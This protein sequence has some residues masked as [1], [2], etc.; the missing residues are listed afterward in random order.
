MTPEQAAEEIMH[1]DLEHVIDGKNPYV[2]ILE[3][4]LKVVEF[5]CQHPGC[6]IANNALRTQLSEA[7]E[8]IERLKHPHRPIEEAPKDGTYFDGWWLIDDE[9]ERV[10]DVSWRKPAHECIS[11]YCDSCPED[12][13]VYAFR[14]AWP[15]NA[16]TKLTHYTPIPDIEGEK[17]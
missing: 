4:I 15:D 9:W 5:G 17:K 8:E 1:A 2:R 7:L 10:P 3:V 12:W 14:Q 11:Q 6:C 13:D 16:W